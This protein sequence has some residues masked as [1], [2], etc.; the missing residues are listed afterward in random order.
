MYSS[1]IDKQKDRLSKLE[2]FGEVDSFLF[3]DEFSTVIYEHSKHYL[4]GINLQNFMEYQ[5]GFKVSLSSQDS[6][7]RN[8]FLVEKGIVFL[9]QFNSM[10]LLILAGY[11]ESADI[12][13]LQ[14]KLDTIV[15]DLKV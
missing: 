14:I 9:Y 6:V 5:D 4:D 12:F 11:R 7:I 15:N 3:F 1:G 8:V 2:A 10:S 13:D